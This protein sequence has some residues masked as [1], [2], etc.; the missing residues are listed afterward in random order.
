[1]GQTG[2][3]DNGGEVHRFARHAWSSA[4]GNH[5]DFDKRL[6]TVARLSLATLRML[7]LRTTLGAAVW[8]S[9]GAQGWTE[10]SVSDRFFFWKRVVEPGGRSKGA[11]F[12]EGR[13]FDK[14][15]SSS[16]IR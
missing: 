3:D 6:P 16:P 4:S 10:G 8:K 5:G 7:F 9:I 13:A 14:A 15:A 11:T 1:M 12:H 2:R